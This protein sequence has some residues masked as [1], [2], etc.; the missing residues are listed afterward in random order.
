M[1]AELEELRKS[2]A[3][4]NRTADGEMEHLRRENVRLA[5][6]VRDAQR[7]AEKL[8]GEKTRHENHAADL[9]H[10]QSTQSDELERTHQNLKRTLDE[11]AGMSRAHKLAS[12]TIETLREEMKTLQNAYAELSRDHLRSSQDAMQCRERVLFPLFPCMSSG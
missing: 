3:Q 11:L 5:A 7:E 10:S 4:Q 1:N 6:E 2:K 8:R 9:E 12:S